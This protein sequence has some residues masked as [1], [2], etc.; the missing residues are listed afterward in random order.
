[1]KTALNAAPY[2]LYF[3]AM[4]FNLYSISLSNFILYYEKNLVEAVFFVIIDNNASSVVLQ[5][6]QLATPFFPVTMESRRGVAT[7]LVSSVSF[8]VDYLG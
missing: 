5:S 1:M 4:K 2:T 6:D 7:F 8:G 3:Y